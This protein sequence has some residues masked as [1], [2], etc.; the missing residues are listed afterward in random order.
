MQETPDQS[1]E[2]QN[3]VSQPLYEFTANDPLSQTPYT[4]KPTANDEAKEETHQPVQPAS[5]TR[6]LPEGS[7]PP[8]QSVEAIRQGLVYPP[9][10]WFYQ[11]MQA[12]TVPPPLPLPP[13]PVNQQP[14]IPIPTQPSAK[15]SRTWIWVVAA[16]LGLALI[17]ACGLCGWAFAS[18]AQQVGGSVTVVDDY[19][20]AIKAQ[21]YAAAYSYLAPQDDINGMTLDKFTRQAQSFDEQYGTVTAYTLNQPSYTTNP[22]T[23]PDLSHF[24]MTVDIT[25]A[26]QKSY[27][28]LLTIR[29]LGGHWKITNFDRI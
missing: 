27:T 23:G 18:V 21:N 4:S 26:K 12:P 1:P 28:V 3:L 19:Y 6:A 25:R 11:N 16:I 20:S 8:V 15:K 7:S 22:D 2:E 10:P 17:S 9:P 24:T 5:I 13:Y 14:P 29:N